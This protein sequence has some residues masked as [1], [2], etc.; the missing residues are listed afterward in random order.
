[1]RT[2]GTGLAGLAALGLALT[3]CGGSDGASTPSTTSSR[4]VVF[5]VNL[6]GL[7]EVPGPGAINGSGNA[8]IVVDPLGTDVC[9]TLQVS[10]IGAVTAAT[11]NEGKAGTQGPVTVTL[12]DPVPD[13][14]RCVAT[15][16]A[17]I[18]GLTSGDRAF[19]VNVAT[20]EYPDGAI[21][22]Q[23]KG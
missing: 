3:A 8:N 23:L 4:Q 2:I 21:R 13:P 9:Y 14:T 6:D 7:A 19:Y 11:I 20:A 1:M 5:N 22:A 18:K 10:G 17:T 15:S 12:K 16:K